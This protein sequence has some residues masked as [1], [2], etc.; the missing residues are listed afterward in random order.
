MTA[1]RYVPQY[2]RIEQA[3]RDRIAAMAPGES[4]PSDAEL[5]VAFGVS[6]MT[7]RHA[8]QLLADEG[9]IVRQ[10]GRGSF[11]A[12]PP[13]HRWANHLLTFSREMERLGRHP[14]S[15]LL[16][17][18]VLPAPPEVARRLRVAPGDPVV[19]VRRLRCADGVPIALETAVL[20][21][22][23]A[24]SLL[25]ADLEAGSL[26]AAVAAAGTVLRRGTATI[27]AELAGPE[28]AA[29]LGIPAGSALLVE[30]RVIL[31]AGGRAVEATESRYPADRYALDVR[32][33]VDPAPA[34]PLRGPRAAGERP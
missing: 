9:L 13:A 22:S 18:A 34:D 7:A 6:R 16:E 4:L 25:G 5:S 28:D 2:R 20:L 21:G 27:G 3:L 17:R 12:E 1:E 31:D 24:P 33:D 29:H 10:P 19:R 11:L 26:H 8:M 14:S 30:R 15:R 23:L 32:F